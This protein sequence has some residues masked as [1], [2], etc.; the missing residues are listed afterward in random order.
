MTRT[1]ALFALISLAACAK[2]A[3][4]AAA[5]PEA[6]SAEAPPAAAA[7]GLQI[8]DAARA[9]LAA[10][11]RTEADRALDAGRH[12]EALLSY[13][14]VQPGMRV[15]ELMAGGGYTVEL[16]ARAVGETGAVYGVNSP[17]ILERFAAAPW[18]ER[19]SRPV[20]ARVTRLD[21]D[22][23]APFP[24]DVRDLDRVFSVLVYHDFIWMGT[25]RAKMNASVFAALR[26]GG[27][28]AVVDHSAEDGSGA[29]DAE[30]LH[31][32]DQAL[33]RAE[34]EAAGFRYVGEADFLRNPA[35]P[36]DW[37]ASPR[38][39]GEQRGTSDRFAMSFVK[40]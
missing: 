33:V 18:A 28:Y 24:E 10:P 15:G 14:D 4:P 30:T 26:S 22:F 7:P 6:A 38:A 31:R 35:D 37:S 25:D 19:L 29:R 9:V 8:S 21:R 23:D 12:P 5:A 34:V 36:R 16:L 17:F 32:V 20:N 1:L 40:P 3:P 39:A 11:D 13:Y 2:T 27:I